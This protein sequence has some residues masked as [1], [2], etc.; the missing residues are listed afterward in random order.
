MLV[1]LSCFVFPSAGELPATTGS[2]HLSG[3][4]VAKNPEEI[5]RLVGYCPQF[6]ALFETLTGREHL[7]LYACIK[8]A[9]GPRLCDTL[10]MISKDTRTWKVCRLLFGLWLPLLLASTGAKERR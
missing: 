7:M 2:A 3:F 1:L 6:D 4:D 10:L 9:G 5:H 8:V